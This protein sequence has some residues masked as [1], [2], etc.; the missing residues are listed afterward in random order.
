M[1]STPFAH[2]LW[3]RHAIFPEGRVTSTKSD[4][5]IRIRSAIFITG[6][7]TARS[8]R[9]SHLPVGIHSPEDGLKLWIFLALLHN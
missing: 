7:H 6:V 4:A 3:A 8:R 9:H 1:T 2:A 5:V